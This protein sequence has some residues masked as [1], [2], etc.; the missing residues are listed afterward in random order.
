MLT[1]WKEV[2]VNMIYPPRC[3][4]CRRSVAVHGQWCRACFQA[5]W[6]PRRLAL[7]GRTSLDG[8]Y[9]L[10]GYRGTARKVLQRLKYGRAFH[11]EQACRYL[12]EQFPWLDRLQDVDWVVP[13]PLAPEKERERGF[14]QTERIFRAW[15]EGHWQWR[16]ALQRVRPTAPQ[17]QLG[18]ISRGDNVK[19]AFEV[20]DPFDVRQKRV[21]LVDDIYT[22]GATM[23]ACA[24]ALKQKGAAGVTGIVIASGAM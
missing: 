15:A 4:G 16:D 3:P 1:N 9:C 13:V 17:W 6:Q 19:R 23:E 21:L 10:C 20:K 11:Y 12:L 8:C 14:N 22:S 2:L 7:K 18:R 5:L 24:R